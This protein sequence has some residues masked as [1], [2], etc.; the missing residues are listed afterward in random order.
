M[1]RINGYLDWPHVGLVVRVETITKRRRTTTNETWY[2]IT[3]A[4]PE[5]TDAATL[6]EWWRGHWGIENREHYVRD[7][8]MGEDANRTRTGSGPQALAACRNAALNVLRA[9]GA[10]NV[11]KA[12]RAYSWSAKRLL[13]K[14][15]IL[16]N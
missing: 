4:G 13:V 5:K 9:D 6:G 10:A 15:R 16:K 14:L 8:T 2:G 12:I 11:A 3:S 1:N 7:V